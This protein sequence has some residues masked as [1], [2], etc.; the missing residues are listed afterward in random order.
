MKDS[1]GLSVTVFVSLCLIWGSNWLAIKV[2]LRFL[3][4]F[5]FAGISFAISTVCLLLITKL[6]HTRFPKDRSSWGVMIFLGLTMMGS[7]YGFQYWGEQYVSSGLAAV[8]FATAPLFVVIFA[9][10]LIE[11]E[12]ITRWRA[13]G[14]VISFGGVSVIFWRELTSVFSWNTQYSLYGAI[15]EVASAAITALAIVVYKRFYADIDRLANLLVQTIIGS[16]FL[17]ILGLCWERSSSFEFTPIAIVTIICLGLSTSLPLIG[18][19]WLLEKSSAINVSTITFI[20]PILALVLGWILLGE[21]VNESTVLGGTLILAGVY[22]TAGLVSP[23]RGGHR[24][25]D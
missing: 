19:Y 18:Y 15:A 3:P 6:F 16:A 17:S 5:T 14:I 4:P 23:S 11:E 22:L 21:Q 20:T 8:L 1:R 24:N 7:G 25:Q 10:F 13:I 2:G 12:R 9:H